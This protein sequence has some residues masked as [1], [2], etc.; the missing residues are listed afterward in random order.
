[1]RGT[2]PR[3]GR[4]RPR[5]LASPA[6]PFNL[7]FE[8]PLA[9]HPGGV[10]AGLRLAPWAVPAAGCV[11]AALLGLGILIGRP[12]VELPP[13]K[14][15]VVKLV[16]LAPKPSPAQQHIAPKVKV[17][18]PPPR[19]KRHVRHRIS[20][21]PVRHRPHPRKVPK[22][23]VI[24]TTKAKRSAPAIPAAAPT[25][26]AARTPSRAKT[27]GS[28]VL[29]GSSTS[30]A[31]AIYAPLPKI[32]ADMRGRSLDTVAVAHFEV[33]ANGKAEVKLIQPTPYPRL[34]A[35]LLQTLSR[36]RFFPAMKHGQPVV[37]EFEVRI[38]IVVD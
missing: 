27:S 19:V 12:Q 17:A 34:N 11:V 7:Q 9:A 33:L 18:P 14:T 13:H 35:L 2:V 37:S 10:S 26:S 5:R 36:W 6:G 20:P 1:M 24:A 21:R 38:P 16:E 22:K 23:P 31:R 3:T 28:T 29:Y 15:I 4:G 30:G 8:A 32:P 25:P